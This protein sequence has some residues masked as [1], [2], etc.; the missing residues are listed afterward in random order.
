MSTPLGDFVRARRDST[1]P[2]SVGLPAGGRRRAPGLRR[3][4]LA[5]LA[6]ISVEYLVRIEQGRDRNPSVSVVSALADALQLDPTEQEHLRY[7]AKLSS[8]SCL[9]GLAQLRLDVRPTVRT[10]LDQ[11]EPG[12]AVLTNRLGD[13]LAY[14]RGFDQL[15]GPTGLL[16]AP[17]PN[18]TRFVFTDRRAHN[19]FPDWEGIAQ[20]QAFDLRLAPAG[21]RSEGLMADLE[22][23]IGHELT[24]RFDRHQVPDRSTQRWH[25]PVAGELRLMR[26]VLELPAADAQQL[27]VLLPADDTTADALRRLRPAPATTLRVVN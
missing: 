22:A 1:R 11:L 5:A 2:G 4:E 19:V 18:L 21:E 3:S 7:L 25:H 26:E 8:G 9:G 6:G 24:T 13:L 20:E 27:V 16:D 15:A 10:L 14:T 12:I 23:A 17:S